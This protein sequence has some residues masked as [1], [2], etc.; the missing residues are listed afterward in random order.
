MKLFSYYDSPTLFSRAVMAAGDLLSWL[1]VPR[2]PASRLPLLRDKT[3][4]LLL[5]RLDGI[6]DNVCSW[7]ALQLLR[8]RLPDTRIS[9]AVGPWTAQLYRECPWVDEI[10]EWDSGLFGVFRGKGGKGL[11]ND[12]SIAGELRKLGMDAGIDLRGDLLSIALLRMVAPATRIAT[13]T[14]GG[15][16]LLTDPLQIN[17]GHEIQ[18]SFDLACT[19][20][21]LSVGQ[22]PHLRDWPRPE[23]MGR[24]RA[25]LFRAGWDESVPTVALCPLALWPWKQWPKERFRELAQRLKKESGLQVVW[26]LEEGTVAAEYTDKGPVFSGPLDEV[27]AALSL[28]HLAVSNDS[29]LMHLAIAAGCKTVQLFGPGDASRFAHH[30]AET[31]LLHDLSCHYNPC[32]R[33]GKC[34][35]LSEG[36][37]LEKISVDSVIAACLQLMKNF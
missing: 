12:L 23:A 4:R 18:R 8:E 27:A 24:A 3:R 20:L 22:A 34:K 37:C 13:V 29:G 25:T 35:N 30:S 19:A 11:S 28:C 33:S 10:I 31:V 21:G 7:P 6:G 2:R 5:L 9:L 17:D 36:W 26:F 14:R 32:T 1:L 15:R 16:R